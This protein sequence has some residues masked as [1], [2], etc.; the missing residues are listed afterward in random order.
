MHNRDVPLRIPSG[1]AN[2]FTHEIE[3]RTTHVFRL[4]RAVV[5]GELQALLGS[6]TFGTIP[7]DQLEAEIV[8]R[9]EA[10]DATTAAKI[11]AS[12]EG[13]GAIVGSMWRHPLL[14]LDTDRHAFPD[15]LAG[16][17]SYGSSVMDE[18][19]DADYSDDEVR[20]IL[21]MVV[22]RFVQSLL[23]ASQAVAGRAASFRD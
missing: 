23:P 13:M 3:G 20:A 11:R 4:P 1:R 17:R 15:D 9:L 14:A 5:A 19:E 22:S 18:L 6:T 16:L 10:G 8:R 21:E 7:K 2:W 12:E